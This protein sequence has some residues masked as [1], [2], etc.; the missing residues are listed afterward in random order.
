L[1]KKNKM[2]SKIEVLEN[3]D[4]KLDEK[5]EKEGVNIENK[6]DENINASVNNELSS[7]NFKLEVRN[8]PKSFGF[9][10]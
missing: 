1:G 2:D 3:N 9:G 10:V 4:E 5:G 7:E 6:N 8:L